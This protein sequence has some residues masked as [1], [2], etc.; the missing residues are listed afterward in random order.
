MNF[1][2]HLYLAPADDDAL[3]GNL[4][5]DF[6]KGHIE[7]TPARYREGIALHRAID[8]FTDG[9]PQVGESKRRIHSDRRRFAGIIVDMCYD[10]FL[11]RNWGD[12]TDEPLERFS[13]RVYGLLEDRVDHLPLR[14][15][16]VL[17]H[18]RRHDWLV[19]YRAPEGIARALDGLSRRLK[20]GEGLHGSGAELLA[21]YDELGADFE[22]FFPQ[23]RAFVQ[24]KT[25]M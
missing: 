16:F 17:P 19:A 11:A 21:N 10:H 13:A 5:G 2:A 12:Y 4:L 15:Q 9:H 23:L 6:V 20:R 8:E 7:D 1:L 25:G 24:Q 3:V 18:M 14:L 22:R